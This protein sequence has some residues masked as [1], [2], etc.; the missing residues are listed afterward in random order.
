[1]QVILLDNRWFRGSLIP[2]TRSDEERTALGITGSMGL[3]PNTS[4]GMTLLGG[5]QWAWRE[6]QLQKAADVRLICSGRQIV[7]DNK[8]MQ[9]WGN[10]S[11]ERQRLFD[12]IDKTKA[13]GVVLLSGNVHYTEIS[14]TDGGAYPLYDFTSSGMTH[15][16][17]F[18]AA[19]K[20]PYRVSGPYTKN[21]FGLVDIDWSKKPSPVLSLTNEAIN[22]D[23]I[24]VKCCIIRV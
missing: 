16:S 12:L 23:T 19:V 17:E 24:T 20:N 18:Y 21:N 9:E 2:D 10:F 13:G 7:N 8:G 15:N 1:M 14:K 11:L 6:D 22:K 3:T 5:P 4:Q